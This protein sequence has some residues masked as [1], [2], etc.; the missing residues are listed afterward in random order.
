VCC[1]SPVTLPF[2]F[3]TGL[4]ARLFGPPRPEVR[5][6]KIFARRLDDTRQAL[7]YAMDLTV[8]GEVAMLLPVPVPRGATDDDLTFVDLSDDAALFDSLAELFDHTPGIAAVARGGLLPQK[9]RS[10]LEVHQVGSFEASFVPDLGSF[11]RLDPRFRLPDSV[12]SALGAYDDWGFAV[13]R[14]RPAKRARIHPMAFRFVSRQ[15]ERLFFP[16]VHVHDG[17]VHPEASFDHLLYWQGAVPRPPAAG[18]V[19][20]ERSPREP[21]FSANGLITSGKTVYRR[22]MRGIRPNEDT[23]I[24]PG[25]S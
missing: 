20:D 23:W 7:A 14:L 18:G 5:N 11:D 17:E 9:S 1:F 13:F 3:F 6:T 25:A 22:S 15:P 4:H 16:T 21:M 2:R 10:R 19:P 8:A 24:V 12:W